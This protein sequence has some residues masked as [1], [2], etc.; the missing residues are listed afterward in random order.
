[1]TVVVSVRVGLSIDVC[2]RA[3]G[4]CA[5]TSRVFFVCFFFVDGRL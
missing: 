2:V 4:V 3:F 5:C 1:M